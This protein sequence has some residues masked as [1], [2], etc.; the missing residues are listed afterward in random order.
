MRDICF[1][2][3]V[4]ISDPWSVGCNFFNLWGL[5]NPKVASQPERPK[6]Q[7]D[8]GHLLGNSTVSIAVSGLVE[9][10]SFLHFSLESLCEL[11]VF[12]ACSW[13]VLGILLFLFSILTS[14]FHLWFSLPM[15]SMEVCLSLSYVDIMTRI[16]RFLGVP[17]LYTSWS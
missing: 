9:T 11:V 17:C 12:L 6:G 3:C 7:S 8:S 4:R 15:T 16:A 1:I 13:R 2:Y 10:L 5:N 14:A